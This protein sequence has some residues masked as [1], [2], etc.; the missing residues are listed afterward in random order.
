MCPLLALSRSYL[1]LLRVVMAIETA[2][3][4]LQ[5]V[6]TLIFSHLQ[7]TE[8]RVGYISRTTKLHS[9]NTYSYTYNQTH[10]CSFYLVKDIKSKSVAN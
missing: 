2:G 5:Q 6:F 7:S 3:A 4:E 1:P 9:M 10:Y 8:N